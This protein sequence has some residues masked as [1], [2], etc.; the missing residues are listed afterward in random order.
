[1]KAA[2]FHGAHQPLTIEQVEL[3]VP[4]P[5]EIRVRTAY[6]GIPPRVEY[7]VTPAGRTLEPVLTALADWGR[8]HAVG[9]SRS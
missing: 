1:M 4:G 2:V 5:H 3:D 7:S 8:T 9:A 6:A